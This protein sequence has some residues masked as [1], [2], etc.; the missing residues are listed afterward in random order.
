MKKLISSLV[1]V[2]IT[3]FG[4]QAQTTKRPAPDN[5]A[6]SK[7]VKVDTRLREAL[8]S[9]GM[10]ETLATRFAEVRIEPTKELIDQLNNKKIDAKTKD[11]VGKSMDSLLKTLSAVETVRVE[12]LSPEGVKI[13][14]LAKK[15]VVEGLVMIMKNSRANL[16]MFVEV[17][18]ALSVTQNTL[19]NAQSSR[20]V[21][22]TVLAV[23]KKA[24]PKL[25]LEDLLNCRF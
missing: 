11:A 23:L 5:K 9:S 1:L 24:D 19:T 21:L 22:D 4:A 20:M 18:S 25:T 12:N 7:E 15:L 6:A 10:D 8:K 14:E 13:N 17:T 3:V 2:T 16:D